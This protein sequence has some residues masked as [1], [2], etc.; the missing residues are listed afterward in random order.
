MTTYYGVNK[1]KTLTPIGGNIL[2]PGLL[3]GRVRCMV[4]T[5][6][7]AAEAAGSIIQMGQALP[8]GAKVLQ[9]MLAFDA[10][11]SATIAVGDLDVVD[12]YLTAT[13]VASAGVV[14]TTEDDNV[15]GIAYE[16]LGTGAT[17]SLD[18][19]QIML[20]TASASIT[21]TIKLIVFYVVD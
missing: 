20:T 11:G 13:S 17:Q 18:D 7:A 8:V 21:G 14:S 15:D 10:L 9:V 5:Y 12:R 19:T 6:E 1:T 2:S 3:G 16:V 4:D